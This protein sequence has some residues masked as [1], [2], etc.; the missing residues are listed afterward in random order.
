VDPPGVLEDP[1][2][3]NKPPE[4]RPP[5]AA[6]P[7]RLVEADP[8]DGLPNRLDVAPPEAIDPN[9]PPDEAAPD[10]GVPNKLVV[11]TVEAPPEDGDP[12]RLEEAAPEVGAPNRLDVL[13]DEVPNSPADG[14]P[15]D[16]SPN[17]LVEDD[18][19]VGAPKRLEVEAAPVPNKL[20]DAA[21][22]PNKPP[23]GAAVP[24]NRLV[25]AA[26]DVAKRPP[27][28][29]GAALGVTE[30]ALGAAFASSF[31]GAAGSLAEPFFS[32]ALVPCSFA[33]SKASLNAAASSAV[34]N[35]IARV[36]IWGGSSEHS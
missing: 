26:P 17:K 6:P 3:A 25:E 9:R 29:P 14:A 11:L 7:K 16:E 19:D 23:V 27:V 18:P 4:K 32:N 35:L 20:P 24:P 2:D 5:V 36:S 31:L 1:D 10:D 12:N 22:P 13:A 8:E 33:F 28:A 30:G 34:L 15:E 21:V